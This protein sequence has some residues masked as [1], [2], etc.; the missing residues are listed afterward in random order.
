MKC[1]FKRATHHPLTPTF[2][3]AITLIV[4]VTSLCGCAST[5]VK[6]TWKSPEFHGGPIGKIAVLAVDERGIVRV[7][8]ENRYVRDLKERG[9]EAMV[10]GEYVDVT[11]IETN[12]E[13]I[14][15]HLR[16]AGAEAILAIKLV[17][18]VSY[19]STVSAAQPLSGRDLYLQAGTWYDYFA[20]HSVQRAGVR[21]SSKREFYL[22]N[23]LFDLKTGKRLWSGLAVLV[24][25]EN[26]DSLEAADALSGKVVAAMQKDGVIR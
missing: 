21:S 23:S 10:A 16:D 3:L 11:E 2:I 6:E 24:L 7:A 22:D 19:Q 15:A 25:K 17:D 26:Q 20:Y 5:S 13:A 14:A 8:L 4:L 12:K 9:Q 18:R 1:K